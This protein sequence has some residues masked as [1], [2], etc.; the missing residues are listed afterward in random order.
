MQGDGFRQLVH[1][2]KSTKKEM[3]DCELTTMRKWLNLSK[4]VFAD[5]THSL[6]SDEILQT[7]LYN[8][9]ATVFGCIGAFTL[10]IIF[11]WWWSARRANVIQIHPQLTSTLSS[12]VAVTS[13]SNLDQSQGETDSILNTAFGLCDQLNAG[14][15]PPATVI[16]GS[17]I[18]RDQYPR[19]SGSFKTVWRAQWNRAGNVA[20]TDV[21]LLLSRAGDFDALREELKVHLLLAEHP[22]IHF[23]A[24]HQTCCALEKLM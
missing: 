20:S 5:S 18:F 2:T 15:S 13:L 11:L 24:P 21:A 7:E 23:I 19:A 12:S 1:C 22:G 10:C 4:A 9:V 6:L 17:R 3:T 16:P 8:T 14:L